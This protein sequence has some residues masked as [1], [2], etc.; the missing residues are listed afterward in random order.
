MLGTWR[1]GKRRR[2]KRRRGK[3]RRGKR[4]AYAGHMEESQRTPVRHES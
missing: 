2:G 3:R 4:R 1:R